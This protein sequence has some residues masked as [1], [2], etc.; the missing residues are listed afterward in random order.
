MSREIDERVVEM[1]FDNA[2]FEHGVHESIDSLDELKK[3]LKF[4][5]SSDGLKELQNATTKF[6]TK[7]MATA[8]ETVSKKFSA[9]EIVTKTCLTKYTVSNKILSRAI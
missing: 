4:E 2:Q 6:D 1:R 3:S 7:P 8:I 9:L 5:D